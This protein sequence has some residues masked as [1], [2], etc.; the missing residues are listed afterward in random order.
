MVNV[1]L[2]IVTLQ[3]I[4]SDKYSQFSQQNYS[5]MLEIRHFLSISVIL[6]FRQFDVGQKKKHSSKLGKNFILRFSPQR[7]LGCLS[8][9]R[10]CNLFAI[11]GVK[12]GRYFCVDLGGKNDTI[13]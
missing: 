2:S 10:K 1:G 4:D 9:T 8:Y 6:V 11:Y 13:R 3:S 5:T 7:E 12:S